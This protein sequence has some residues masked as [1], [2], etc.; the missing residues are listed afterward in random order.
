M[1]L[2]GKHAGIHTADSAEMIAARER[3]VGEGLF[4]PVATAVAQEVADPGLE[5]V[6]GAIVDLGSGPGH[7]LD[8]A[9]EAAPRRIGV[10]V[11]N[12]KF[13]ARRAARCH[14]RAS[15]VVADIWDEIPLRSGSAAIVLNVFAPRNGEE[16]MRVLAPGGAL[17]V[18]TP[19]PDHLKELI[20]PFSMISV[21]AEKDRR[22]RETLG[23]LGE[24]L[25]T[26][27]LTWSM[28]LSRQ[29]VADMVAMGPSAD[30]MQA[31]EAEALLENLRLPVPVTGSVVISVAQK[32]KDAP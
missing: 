7:Y 10:A 15:A 3:V 14:P 29:E 32:P 8:R 19:G 2:L 17:I 11:D 6:D 12:S 5:S 1:S 22:L 27:E 9:L 18:V 30:R 13:A 24:K 28:N 16:I 23:D 26:S 31:A 20:E 25:R 21:D 4:E